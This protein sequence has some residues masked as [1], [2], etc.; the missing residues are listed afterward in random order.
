MLGQL[1]APL[2]FPSL[3]LQSSFAWINTNQV[4][5]HLRPTHLPGDPAGK[6]PRAVGYSESAAAKAN[7]PSLGTTVVAQVTPCMQ[8]SASW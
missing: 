4:L 7:P 3:L 2:L 8:P 1:Q 5:I 6:G